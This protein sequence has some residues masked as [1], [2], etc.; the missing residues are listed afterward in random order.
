MD[1]NTFLEPFQKPA[2]Q[3]NEFE[4]ASYL[5]PKLDN[6]YKFYARLLIVKPL[7]STN[8]TL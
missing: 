1:D 3:V 4:I 8:V 7:V 2:W 5:L 6:V